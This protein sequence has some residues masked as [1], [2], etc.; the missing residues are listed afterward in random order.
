[1]EW[2]SYSIKS[3]N[4]YGDARKGLMKLFVIQFRKEEGAY[5]TLLKNVWGEQT[6]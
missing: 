4:I 6:H 3:Q 2:T 5:P 1:M